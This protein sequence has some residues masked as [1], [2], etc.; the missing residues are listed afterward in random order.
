[1]FRLVFI[2]IL[3]LPYYSFAQSAVD[4]LNK[5]SILQMTKDGHYHVIYKKQLYFC[6]IVFTNESKNFY[7]IKCRTI[8]DKKE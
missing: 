8:I 5:G 4:I 1:M 7:E 2:L 3:L 6:H